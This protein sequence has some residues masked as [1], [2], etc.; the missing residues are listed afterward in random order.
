MPWVLKTNSKLF[1]N[2]RTDQDASETNTTKTTRSAVLRLLTRVARDPRWQLNARK[3]SDNDPMAIPSFERD[4][5]RRLQCWVVLYSNI[6]LFSYCSKTK[7]VSTTITWPLF[8]KIVLCLGAP[9]SSTGH[10]LFC[11]L[12]MEEGVLFSVG[13][14][15]RLVSPWGFITSSWR[16]RKS[17]GSLVPVLIDFSAQRSRSSR[18]T[19]QSFPGWRVQP[20][21][22]GDKELRVPCRTHM[23]P[24]SLRLTT[25]KKRGS[26]LLS[27]SKI[28]FVW[29]K[30]W[31][32]QSSTE[33]LNI[34]DTLFGVSRLHQR[35]VVAMPFKLHVQLPY[36]C[37]ERFDGVEVASL[38]QPQFIYSL[39]L[40][41]TYKSGGWKMTQ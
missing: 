27:T 33:V 3:C 17:T 24:P 41:V 8:Y 30:T 9:H 21:P 19:H 40:E 20:I 22:C 5:T 36:V 1:D 28:V 13:L 37:C 26:F 2:R 7:Q 31:G 39:S 4:E 29:R 25:C 6:F 11:F 23:S 10:G 38:F 14:P 12:Q 18:W 34:L 16:W 35:V 32:S 15:N